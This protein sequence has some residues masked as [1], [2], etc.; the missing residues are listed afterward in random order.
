M[1]ILLLSLIILSGCA[2][3]KIA[4]GKIDKEVKAVVISKEITTDES[5]KNYIIKSDKLN[6]SQKIR[7]VDLQDNTKRL[8]GAVTE[9]I[10]KTKVVLLETVLEKKM[11]LRE[12]DI[13]KKKIVRLE[14]ERVEIG[15][16][17]LNEARNIINPRGDHDDFKYYSPYLHDHF[18]QF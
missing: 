6:D 9:K 7:L 10:E 13:L 18:G 14:K 11:S 16:K 5:T 4:E 12:Y 1:K 8:T 2:Q 17:A 15:F 3:Q